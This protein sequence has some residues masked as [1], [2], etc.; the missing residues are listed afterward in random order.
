MKRVGIILVAL[1]VV[2][3]CASAAAKDQ[4]ATINFEVVKDEN[5]KPVR[6]AAVI[7]HPV[8]KSGKQHT[9]GQEL[10]T[11]KDGKASIDYVPY[12]V[13]RVQVI[14]NGR[15]TYGKDFEINQ[16]THEITIKLKQPQEQY[17]I[18]GNDK[19]DDKK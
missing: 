9:S 14:A 15:Q 3:V 7:L 16:P 8:S 11:D 5:G 13:W 6:N 10:K 2:G 17:S 4:Y 1:M 18:Y 19:K 12:G